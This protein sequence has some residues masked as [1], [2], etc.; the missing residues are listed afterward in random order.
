VISAAKHRHYNEIIRNSENKIKRTWKIIN[1]ERGKTRSRPIIQ[2]LKI[3]NNIVNNQDDMANIF[4]NY[5]LS[6]AD[7][8]NKDNKSNDK[9]TNPLH[10]PPNFIK[11]PDN[12][13]EW[14]YAT[15]YELEKIIRSLKTK[16]SCGHEEISN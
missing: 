5:F 2:F 14:K 10:Y 7:L 15:T 1:E 8:L 16:N 13:M 6:V 4:N 3:N 11:E 9:N 12:K